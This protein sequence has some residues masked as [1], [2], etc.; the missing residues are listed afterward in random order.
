MRGRVQLGLRSYSNDRY[1]DGG[2]TRIKLLPKELVYL[3]I[4]NKSI[5]HGENDD[6]FLR[7]NRELFV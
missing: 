4:R 6:T 2:E 3:A 1:N 5:Y 7:M